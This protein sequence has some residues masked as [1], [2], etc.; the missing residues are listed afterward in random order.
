MALAALDR[1]AEAEKLL[2]PLA[3]E[4][5]FSHQ[6]EAALT[7][8]SLLEAEG[9]PDAALAALEPLTR[10]P[11]TALIARKRAADFFWRPHTRPFLSKR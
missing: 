4:P 7:R 2:A 9:D 10:N 8:A 6:Q 3:D 11:P 1:P 5:E